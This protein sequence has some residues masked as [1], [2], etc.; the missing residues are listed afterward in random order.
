MMKIESFGIG[1]MRCT[2]ITGRAKQAVKELG[3]DAEVVKVQDIDAIANYRVLRLPALALDGVIKIT[4]NVPKVKK[5]KEWIKENE[6]KAINSS[7]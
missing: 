2:E 6:L 7:L 1:C 5:I 3:I 4:G